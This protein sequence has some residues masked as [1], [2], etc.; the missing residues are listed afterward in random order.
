MGT[1]VMRRSLSL[2]VAVLAGVAA[3]AAAAGAGDDSAM[4]FECTTSV[5]WSSWSDVGSKLSA[6]IAQDLAKLAAVKPEQVRAGDASEG[7]GGKAKVAIKFE[8]RN[9]DTDKAGMEKVS[10]EADVNAALSKADSAVSTAA[11]AAGLAGGVT[12]SACKAPKEASDASRVAEALA[13]P[14]ASGAEAG[15]GECSGN[16]IKDAESGVCVCDTSWFGEKCD[17]RQCSNHGHK[18]QDVCVCNPGYYGE[19]CSMKAC[20][21]HGKAGKMFCVCDFGYEGPECSIECSNHGSV[22]PG[23]DHCVCDVEYTGKLCQTVKH[24]PIPTLPHKT[25][26]AGVCEA[27]DLTLDFRA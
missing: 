24:R 4:E 7:A 3:A 16:G 15:G 14:P 18:V 20:N 19:D 11:A 21:G 8:L 26:V 23:G 1:L 12:V 10:K 2:A 22:G 27:D 25:K 6:A 9:L 5:P 13:T 17:Q